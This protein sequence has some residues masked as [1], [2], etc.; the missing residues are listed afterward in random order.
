MG[1]RRRKVV[2]IPKKR[3]PKVFLCPKCGK[4]GV[5]VELSKGQT[6]A[7]VR[8]GSCGLMDELPIKPAFREIDVYC[9]FTD[10]FYS[11]TTIM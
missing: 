11:K 5:R 4:E 7:T 3:L 9:L 6:R 8:C 1:R 2:R 10:K